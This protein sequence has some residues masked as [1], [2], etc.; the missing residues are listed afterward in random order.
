MADNSLNLSASDTTDKSLLSDVQD[1]QTDANVKWIQDQLKASASADA[2]PTDPTPAE[3]P[4]DGQKPGLIGRAFNDM[5]N[6]VSQLPDAIKYGSA[7]AM[8][9]LLKSADEFADWMDTADP[10]TLK[11]QGVKDPSTYQ[12]PNTPDYKHI[13]TQ[14]LD[15]TIEGQGQ[16]ADASGAYQPGH[17]EFGTHGSDMGATQAA[18][19]GSVNARTPEQKTV[20]GGL[21][22]GG[23]QFMVGMLPF[24]KGL[25]VAM[26]G[27][28]ATGILSAAGSGAFAMDPAEGMLSNLLKDWEGAPDLVRAAASYLAVDE[29]DSTSVKRLKHAIEGAGM[30]VIGDGIVAAFGLIKG[31]RATQGITAGAPPE[32]LPTDAV[33]AVRESTTVQPDPRVAVPGSKEAVMAEARQINEQIV[34]KMNEL[35][36]ATTPTITTQEGVTYKGK[37][38]EQ[39]ADVIPQLEQ[40]LKDSGEMAPKEAL[41]GPAI[42][43][44]GKVYTGD[45]HAGAMENALK[46]GVD[47]TKLETVAENNAFGFVT[48]EGRFI[49]LDEATAVAKKIGQ[50]PKDQAFTVTADQVKAVPPEGLNLKGKTID[51]VLGSSEY[52][53]YLHKDDAGVKAS[54]KEIQD[55]QAKATQLEADMVKAKSSADMAKPTTTEQLHQLGGKGHDEIEA[56]LPKGVTPEEVA[57]IQ[58]KAKANALDP[59]NTP[60]LTEEEYKIL[61]TTQTRE[62]GYVQQGKFMTPEEAM[63]AGQAEAMA[64]APKFAFSGKPGEAF[65]DAAVEQQF[66]SGKATL[67]SLVKTLDTGVIGAGV[68]IQEAVTRLTKF[69]QRELA[70]NAKVDIKRLEKLSRRLG[71]DAY[72][73]VAKQPDLATNPAKI[74]AYMHL[75]DASDNNLKELAKAIVGDPKGIGASDS[76]LAQMA[77]LL[78]VRTA[79]N[80]QLVAG[81]AT[82]EI[83]AA[84]AKTP[85]PSGDVTTQIMQARGLVSKFGG[86]NQVRRVAAA[87]NN[88]KD[89]HD[90]AKAMH[91]SSLKAFGNAGTSFWYW[92]LI[93]GTGT[94]AV[95]FLSTG[96]NLI[97]NVAARSLAGNVNRF[98]G[99]TNG[100]VAG[101]AKEM[102]YGFLQSF[103]SAS[104]ASWRA[105]LTG[106]SGMNKFEANLPQDAVSQLGKTMNVPEPVQSVFD[107]A[108]WIMNH[109][110]TNILMGTDEFFRVVATNMQMRALALREATGKGLSG[111]ALAQEIERIMASPS[112]LQKLDAANFAK[113]VTFTKELGEVGQKGQDFLNRV[114]F[115]KIVVP[116]V[117]T[118]VNISKQ[119]LSNGPLGL[120]NLKMMKDM[121]R[122]GARGQ[123][124]FAK[125]MMGTALGSVIV[126]ESLNGR[127]TAYGPRSPGLRKTWLLDHRPYSMKIPTKVANFLN[128]EGYQVKDDQGDYTWVSYN[129]YD[130]FGTMIGLSASIGEVFGQL[131]PKDF[132]DSMSMLGTA[133]SQTFVNKTWVSGP[134]GFMEALTDPEGEG[135]KQ[136]FQRQ[137]GT[138]FIPNIAGQAVKQVDPI[139]RDTRSFTDNFWEDVKNQMI[140][141]VPWLSQDLEPRLNRWGQEIYA[142][143]L[144]PDIISALYQSTPDGKPI[145][146]WLWNNQVEIQMPSPVQWGD[147]DNSGVQLT[148]KEYTRF[149]K[150]AGNELKD[151]S[152]GLGL[153]D[154]L[155]AIMEGKHVESLDWQQATDG[156]FGGR[157][158][159][160]RN[161]MSTFQEAAKNQLLQESIDGDGKLYHRLEQG[162]Q[163]MINNLTIGPGGE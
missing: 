147:K 44:D 15:Q 162:Q 38:G 142:Q 154:T 20:T 140:S 27:R 19:P 134:A 113:D 153:Y 54:T 1:S 156:P 36:E 111:K 31:M 116:F 146:D 53:T 80:K 131:H 92:A 158:M 145:N 56:T 32:V 150:L 86:A 62:R 52:N 161:L 6:S 17:I 57:A 148:P 50:A 82:K 41:K 70:A 8:V 155:N 115:G 39:H 94:H 96:S 47:E 22:Q 121:S 21:V 11:S 107:T 105:W 101:E 43:V 104:K 99:G 71:E 87:I 61:R 98:L 59:E 23:T 83:D 26:L 51:D 73:M 81:G 84:L 12:E 141:R 79:M 85:A 74:D 137:V 66:L 63:K 55:L 143:S 112:D 129:R 37:P 132:G 110:G 78:N 49:N 33:P 120:L 5:A 159:I 151:P 72:S 67:K 29:N 9:N 14:F 122:G 102:M 149:V 136:W 138:L 75:L 58:E 160:V 124:A 30:Q 28:T 91:P 109:T 65:G 89:I 46:A 45:T 128:M 114:P 10:E 7:H 139:F 4:A 69:A 88:M 18:A 40:A 76:Y 118:P 90:V 117:R 24:V 163:T 125:A 25:K 77:R 106:E 42:E 97:W 60:M 95:N 152:T 126:E 64:K 135:A 16:P 144:G 119:A 48:N 103:K 3:E 157:A 123:V 100:V 34:T 68:H 130:P 108:G 13:V 2:G 35:K 127:I 133:A 93:S